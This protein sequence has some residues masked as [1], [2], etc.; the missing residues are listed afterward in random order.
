MSSQVARM[1][2]IH[3]TTYRNSVPTSSHS[4]KAATQ[5][6][7]SGTPCRGRWDCL[8][9][10]FVASSWARTLTILLFRFAT[11]GLTGSSPSPSRPRGQLR[12]STAFKALQV[13]C[14]CQ[15]LTSVSCCG[16]S[17]PSS[18]IESQLGIAC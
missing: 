18:V 7:G 12:P 3:A 8:H 13:T 14:D 2:A 15:Y 16:G 6:V 1:I 11:T 4:L 5:Q 9:L 17:A 10:F